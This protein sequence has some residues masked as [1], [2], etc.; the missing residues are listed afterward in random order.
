MKNLKISASVLAIQM[1]LS[2][3]GTDAKASNLLERA[4]LS[5][6]VPP[7]LAKRAGS[8]NIADSLEAI[9]ALNVARQTLSEDDARTRADGF[10]VLDI[11][12]EKVGL[13]LTFEEA[14]AILASGVAVNDAKEAYNPAN[15]AVINFTALINANPAPT[16]PVAGTPIVDS[17]ENRLVALAY[18]TNN[19]GAITA[20]LFEQALLAVRASIAAPTANQLAA[21]QAILAF[22]N[23]PANAATFASPT[24]DDINAADEIVRN[25]TGGI[26][27]DKVNATKKLLKPDT[28]LAIVVNDNNIAAADTLIKA[29]LPVNADN[30]TDAAAII[31][32]I[33]AAAVTADNLVA[34]AALRNAVGGAVA[35]DADN[36]A[37]AKKLLTPDN[38]AAIVVNTDNVAAADLLIKGV[39]P[40]NA[41]N[42]ITADIIVDVNATS[43]V[44]APLVADLA[45]V[46]LFGGTNKGNMVAA[47]TAIET[48]RAAGT[49]FAGANNG[50]TAQNVID[51]DANLLNAAAAVNQAAITA[52]IAAIT[53]MD[54]AATGTVVGGRTVKN[55]QLTDAALNNVNLADVAHPALDGSAAVTS[56]Q[57]DVAI[58]A[59]EAF[60]AAPGNAA[61]VPGGVTVNN[62]VA[63]R[64]AAV[65]G[66]VTAVNLQAAGVN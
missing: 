62:V 15:N 32:G 50:L 28:G 29:S 24:A 27:V 8:N 52:A 39:T 6:D 45:T 9:N 3:T 4:C 14:N 56:A 47:A 12:A 21:A 31:A 11:E 61:I 59:L 66:G 58:V 46:T 40:V 41:A 37:A 17:G 48:V 26:T 38:G 7:A 43:A 5:A 10:V 64:R 51:V 13:N 20:A 2:L 1:A 63:A 36:V 54:V 16:L 25:A 49:P 35:V 65:A 34:A 53:A 23:L 33:N 22:R 60:I 57:L 18:A 42:V 30:V 19:P 55:V 44:S